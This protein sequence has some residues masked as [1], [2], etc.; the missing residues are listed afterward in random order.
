M[1]RHMQRDTKTERD[2]ERPT[3][4]DRPTNRQRQRQTESDRLI[5]TLTDTRGRAQTLPRRLR[6]WSGLTTSGEERSQVSAECRATT[7]VSAVIVATRIGAT[8]FKAR[9]RMRCA[10]TEHARG[11]VS[12]SQPATHIGTQ[13]DR[14]TCKPSRTGDKSDAADLAVCFANALGGHGGGGSGEC[15]CETRTPSATQRT[16][17]RRSDARSLSHSLT[18]TDTHVCMR[19]ECRWS[20]PMQGDGRVG[21]LRARV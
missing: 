18:C 2:R 12:A 13:T 14:D 11:G 10:H 20:R 6:S 17:C 5:Q 16:N 3:E 4:T 9:A 19:T 8:V 1:T 15:R 21:G 7:S